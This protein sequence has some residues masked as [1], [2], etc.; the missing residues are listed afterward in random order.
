MPA[1]IAALTG[2]ALFYQDIV[3]R[4]RER[5]KLDAVIPNGAGPFPYVVFYHGGGFWN[6]DKSTAWATGGNPSEAAETIAMVNAGIA[7]FSVN[8]S[9]ISLDGDETKGLVAQSFSDIQYSM[10]W[11]KFNAASFNIIK[12][13]CG[14]HGNSAGGNAAFFYSHKEFGQIAPSGIFSESTLPVCVAGRRT[15]QSLDFAEQSGVTTPLTLPEMYDLT[16]VPE[17]GQGWF[18]APEGNW[19]NIFQP[20][21]KNIRRSISPIYRNLYNPASKPFY[22]FQPDDLVPATTL[23]II[24]HNPNSAL[25]FVLKYSEIGAEL[26]VN[27]GGNPEGVA[28]YNLIDAT[29][30]DFMISKLI[31]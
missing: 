15:I 26:Q 3:Y 31:S 25:W 10:M 12:N 20:I 4:G 2:S 1:G 13:Q 28:N 21:P 9:F 7:C 8:Y 30:A 27:N 29:K 19:E 5:C 11:L 22:L 23:D 6:G 17:F 16:G 24:G 18:L 14:Y